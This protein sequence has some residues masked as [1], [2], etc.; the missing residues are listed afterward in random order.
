MGKC[1]LDVDASP[2]LKPPRRY[3]LAEG[4]N[5][6]HVKAGHS[7]EGVHR[8]VVGDQSGL[9]L[10]V[11]QEKAGE[12]DSLSRSPGVEGVSHVLKSSFCEESLDLTCHF[13][14]VRLGEV[15]RFC[16]M[17]KWELVSF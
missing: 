14:I 9:V 6:V 7:E 1:V 4:A 5:S 13:G 17:G 11:D 8:C 12:E 16:R 10:L 15:I 2:I 3:N